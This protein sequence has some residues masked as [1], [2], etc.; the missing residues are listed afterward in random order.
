MKCEHDWKILSTENEGLWA[1]R[2]CKLCGYKEARPGWDIDGLIEH[3]LWTAI[4]KLPQAALVR[5]TRLRYGAKQP[6]TRQ[7]FTSIMNRITYIL[8]LLKAIAPEEKWYDQI[9]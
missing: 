4:M 6:I 3:E 7:E 5:M 9:K 1:A 8:A 2:F